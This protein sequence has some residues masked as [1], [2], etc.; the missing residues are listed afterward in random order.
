MALFGPIADGG[1]AMRAVTATVA[2]VAGAAVLLVPGLGGLTRLLL[3][4]A[5]AVV[6]ALRAGTRPTLAGLA[7]A[8]GACLVYLATVGRVVRGGTY[9]AAIVVVAAIFGTLAGTLRHHKREQRSRG[10][11]ASVE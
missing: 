1:G 5:V 8:L 2:A 10:A 3:A 7:A 9:D 6:A 4:I 11:N